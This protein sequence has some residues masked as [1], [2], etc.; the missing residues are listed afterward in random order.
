MAVSVDEFKAN[1]TSRRHPAY[2]DSIFTTEA[3]EYSTSEVLLGSAYRDLVLDEHDKDVDLGK[4][5]DLVNE[6]PANTGGRPVWELMLSQQGGIASPMLSGQKGLTRFRQLMP[7]VPRVAHH[8]CVRGGLRGRWFP[9]NLLLQTIGA[10]R[11]QVAG[12]ELI[13]HLGR[14]LDVDEDDDIFAR[15][16]DDAFA[17]AGTS[18]VSP[19]PYLNQ[20]L[21]DT[22]VRAFRGNAAAGGLCSPAEQL[23]KDLETVVGLKRKL[24]RRQWVVLVEAVMRLGLGMHILWTCHVNMAC[25]EMVLATAGGEPLSSE[26]EIE[27]AVWESH[28]GGDSFLDLGRDAMPS[29]RQLLGRYVYARFGL[30]LTLYKLEDAGVP[31]QPEYI[32][33]SPQYNIGAARSIFLLL[34][35]IHKNRLAIDADSVRWLRSSCVELLDSRSPLVKCES[36]FTKNMLEFLRH[37]LGQMA[38]GDPEQKSYDQ[39]YLLADTNTRKRGGRYSF[40]LLPGP[41]MLIMLVHA[42]CRSQ[43]DI[44]ASLEDLRLHL[45]YYGLRVPA[46]ELNGGRVGADLAKLGLVVDSPDAAGGRLL[47]DPF[48]TT[49]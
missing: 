33:H 41:A 25:W 36:G 22:E 20:N 47:V 34:E 7:L 9:A 28:A 46:G 44:P 40:P 14:A 21:D 45:A 11:G 29:I 31:F 24:T 17:E 18:R 30:N 39:S 27:R 3:P 43:G 5:P 4:L 13:E 37:S 15:F 10:G 32:G 38:T 1:P 35:H 19:P 16:V 12:K 23:C 6:F 48:L 26:A 2:D 42:C 8:A 49:S